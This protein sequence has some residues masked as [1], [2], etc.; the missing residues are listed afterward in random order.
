MS[1]P[2]YSYLV[3]ELLANYFQHHPANKGSKY[4]VILE[5]AEACIALK[6]AFAESKKS[7]PWKVDENIF[8][9]PVPGLP[10]TSYETVLFWPSEDAPGLIIGDITTAT[11]DYL[12]TLRNSLE[13]GNVNEDYGVIFI[14]NSLRTES[15]ITASV[16]L[17]SSHMPLHIDEISSN[18]QAKINDATLLEYEKCFLRDY[19]E[20]IR[21]NCY[22]IYE[23]EEV[24]SVL[25]EQSLDRYYSKLGYF[26]HKSLT[27]ALT[28]DPKRTAETISYNA[29]IFHQISRV[30]NL[31][32]AGSRKVELQK[33]LDDKLADKL[34]SDSLNWKDTDFGDILASIHEKEAKADY[35]LLDVTI[36][37]GHTTGKLLQ[38][39]SGSGKKKQLF[40]VVCETS[41]SQT[42]PVRIRFNKSVKSNVAVA[43]TT[44]KYDILG[45]RINLDL[46]DDFVKV[47]VSENK[48]SYKLWFL[49]VKTDSKTFKYISSR[50]KLDTKGRVVVSIPEG[51]SEVILGAGE[52]NIE[53]YAGS[54]F[55]EAW[56]DDYCL[57]I[58]I[59]EEDEDL[60]TVKMS[61]PFPNREVEFK[62]I[63]NRISIVPS[64]P[65][66]IFEKI[67]TKKKSFANSSSE[68][69]YSKI[70]NGEEEF[71]LEHQF[72]KY[73][74]ME[75]QMLQ[76]NWRCCRFV[77]MG[78]FSDK[79]FEE[80]SLLLPPAVE[81]CLTEIYEYYRTKELI[82]S[83]TY[84]DEELA[85]LY[86]A[87]LTQ[88]QQCIASIPIGSLMTPEQE[89][90][91]K[92][93]VIISEDAVWFTPFHPAMIAYMLEFRRQ[94]N[95]TELA[96]PKVLK[97]ITP[98]Y[99]L[100]YI[101]MEH[102]FMQPY[103]DDVTE[104]LKQWM[105]FEKAKEL[106]QVH[107]YNVA[108]RMVKDRMQDF[109]R[110][111]GYLFQD[112]DSPVIISTIGIDDDTYVVE[113]ILKFLREE[114]INT[115]K[116]Q[117]VE[118][119]EYVD[120]ITKETFFERLN[121]LNT[122][123][124]VA[125]EW[126]RVN[127]DLKGDNKCS[128]S[129]L[130]RLLFTRTSFFK[131]PYSDRKIGYCHIAFYQMDTG[132]DF[133][134]PPSAELRSE[135]SLRG[136]I[137]M[138]STKNSE[139]TK[140]TIG[141]GTEGVP[142]ESRKGLQKIM[143]LLN[144][145]YA[146][147][148]NNSYSEGVTVAKNYV[149]KDSTLL[150]S[151]YDHAN[152]V[153]F[154][155]PEVDLDFFYKQDLY[156]VHYTDQYT[157]NARYDAITVTSHKDQYRN[158]L[159]VF[160]GNLVKA[161]YVSQFQE[162]LLSYFNSLN[163]EWLLKVLN[164]T[165]DKVREKMSIVATSVLMRTFM[166]RAEGV[167]WIPIS[168]EEILRVTGSIGLEQDSFFSKK[169]LGVKG[170]TSD[171]LLML[172]AGKDSE[173]RVT[174]Y[175]YPVEVK[176]SESSSFRVKADSQ[177]YQTFHILKEALCGEET[178][179]RNV[180]KTFFASQYL[181]TAEKMH[182]NHLLSQEE[183]EDI[184]LMRYDLMN[185]NYSVKEGVSEL[186]LCDSA[187][188]SFYGNSSL[189]MYSEYVDDVNVCHIELGLDQCLNF[190]VDPSGSIKDALL[191]QEIEVQAKKEAEE[192]V[193]QEEVV[194]ESDTPEEET[195]QTE[196]TSNE[197]ESS[198]LEIEEKPLTPE[199]SILVG[200]TRFGKRPVRF[201]PNNSDL[202]SHPNL[203]II[204]TMGTG[205]TQFASSVVAQFSKE[206]IHNVGGKPIGMLVFDYKGD[207]KGD[208]FLSAV[209]GQCF[210]SQFPFNP[211]KL[212]ISDDIDK[213]AM[214]LPAIT[215]DRISDSFAKAYGLGPVQ[216]S[217]IK[218]VVIATYA[219]KG[220]TRD[221]STW[222]I[223]PPT[224][225]D[226][227]EK[228]FAEHDSNDKTY[229]LFSKLQDYTIF[230]PEN[231][232]CVSL[233]EWLDGV[234]VIDLTLYPDDTKRVIVSLILDLFYEEMKQLGKSRVEGN[235]RE[236]RAMIMVDEAHQFLKKDFNALRKIISEGRMFGVGMILSTQNMSD[237]RS[238]ED[239]SQ[240]ILSWVIHN[241]NAINKA[242][243]TSIFGASD[244]C[245]TQYMEYIR[246]CGRF[247]SLCKLGKH[248]YQVRDLPFFELVKTDERF[249]SSES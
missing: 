224:M 158:L 231:S 45:H 244:N 125:V 38:Q 242:D 36:G 137:S 80:E 183:Y 191:T 245:F 69:R 240:F 199:I 118:L 190:V 248:V 43:C 165:A 19:I 184:L 37:E 113:G 202:V 204:G 81:H 97:L 249:S 126:E 172:G 167:L 66:S 232:H 210:K 133:G 79:R 28:L 226:V 241:V 60:D 76:R 114:Y 100:P 152:W 130:I 42:T 189:L 31:V 164:S 67:W 201:L 162:T 234:K 134:T 179:S 207:Y 55:T 132:L 12:T 229:A 102:T 59:A 197:T 82:P 122:D 220:I 193:E 154:L 8:E 239:Y 68:D 176:A 157:I 35:K 91:K 147:D 142:S 7:I 46:A 1:Q 187:V 112:K 161:D 159:S 236:L 117:R 185:L 209:Q 49:R 170:A 155:S 205:K 75:E 54:S 163:G 13:P 96:N 95:E 195:S 14:L 15:L 56:D 140:Y 29:E 52:N 188:V 98:F 218:Q 26:R 21:D 10:V 86:E 119:H 33:I 221:S 194:E 17:M 243:L 151:V 186:G 212:I 136:L 44:S 182:A 18:I 168:L 120:Y 178:F 150:Q 101:N 92:I 143:S 41:E 70:T 124:K 223:T 94:F 233:F 175:F 34:L 2:F 57:H 227:V 192:P 230:T 16:N 237:F 62:I 247:E 115:G 148:E 104:E 135:L 6:N 103:C 235:H 27:E 215:A 48:T 116:V 138:P 214:N 156:I 228:Y 20:R 40:Y 50:F 90:L 39:E 93:G 149:F 200:H 198:S 105:F 213:G 206:S 25:K 196:D 166:R 169:T 5:N 180:Y 64:K 173:G 111:F 24:L 71:S 61:I 65:H 99:L 222:D 85:G 211:L 53:M 77:P 22:S 208:E 88:L 23:F 108:T 171:D 129:E 109:I 131:H 32:E 63:L 72:R 87:F 139:G 9:N 246:D 107:T 110:H 78:N 145:L 83:L 153:T 89:N 216:Q 174:F 11:E 47:E 127:L 225:Q 144:T 128:I 203:A 106:Q 30:F 4:Y 121:R 219:D 238:N 217:T 146:N 160:G 181:T 73:L 3:E 141:F 74:K 51:E 123:E 84:I 177:V 58:K